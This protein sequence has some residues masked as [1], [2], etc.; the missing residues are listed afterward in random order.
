VRRL[1]IGFASL[2][3]VFS[4]SFMATPAHATTSGFTCGATTKPIID[5]REKII[6]DVDSGIAGNYWAFDTISR[7]IRVWNMGGNNYCGVV[8]DDAEFRGVAGQISPGNTNGGTHLLTGDEHG[9]FN[10]G[11][12]TTV[13]SGTLYVAD[14]VNWP[15]KGKVN[16]GNPV[17]Y[18][19]DITGNCPGYIDWTGKYFTNLGNFNLAD[20][21]WK[22]VADPKIDGVWVNALTGNSGDIFDK[23]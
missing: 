15:L 5:V 21:G 9:N 19:C 12:S 11:Y 3:V 4:W 16:G 6:N 17:N 10:G 23:D 2:L 14:P 8:N 22:Y 20:W 1:L 18:N 13:F 7:R